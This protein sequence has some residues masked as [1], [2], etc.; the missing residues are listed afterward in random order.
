MEP[1]DLLRWR[2][3]VWLVRKI[4]RE[5]V[6]AVVESQC[7]H[8]EVI[9]SDLDQAEACEVWCQPAQQWP[10]AALPF[11]SG[12]SRLLSV[13]HGTT[14]LQRFAQW[15]KL[16]DFQ[17]GGALYLN[18]ELNLGYSDRLTAFFSGP[19]GLIALPVEI[20]RNF[21]PL[22]MRHASAPTTGET[23]AVPTASRPTP[24]LFARLKKGE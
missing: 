22:P 3:Q 8:Y 18:P 1:G 16:D 19:R 20:P 23:P 6:T 24:G 17:I 5:L 12:A 21:V 13:R 4:D 7:R 10:S 9:P 2:D 11:K 14:V 15:V